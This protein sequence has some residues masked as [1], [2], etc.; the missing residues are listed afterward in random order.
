MSN[1][2]VG[3][4]YDAIIDDVIK[5][6]KDDF[7]ESGVEE[8]VLEALRDV[9]RATARPSFPTSSLLRDI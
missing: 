2:A 6:S 1:P 4:V 7:D 5:K 8:S 9:S 3:A